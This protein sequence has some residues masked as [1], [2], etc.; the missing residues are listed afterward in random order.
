[1]QSTIRPNKVT[2]IEAHV[3]LEGQVGWHTR[4]SVGPDTAAANACNADEASKIRDV[5]WVVDVGQ[6]QTGRDRQMVNEDSERSK[7]AKAQ[8]DRI[9]PERFGLF[10]VIFRFN[11]L[12]TACP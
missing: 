5:G 11:L 4:Y 6:R 8:G 1:M 9:W 12:R 2:L 10:A 3:D 7:R